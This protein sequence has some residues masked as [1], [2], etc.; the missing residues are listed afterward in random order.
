[1]A[2]LRQVNSAVASETTKNSDRAS[3]NRRRTGSSPL[4]SWLQIMKSA[5]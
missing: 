4:S 1:M 2:W 5:G 3:A